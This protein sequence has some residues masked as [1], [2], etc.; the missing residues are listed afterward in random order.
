MTSPSAPSAPGVRRAARRFL[1]GTRAGATL[2]VTAAVAVMSVAAFAFVV[3]HIWLVDQRDVLKSAASAAAV[4][5]TNEM[6][7]RLVPSPDMS[8]ADLTAALTP[9]ARNYLELNLAYL[10]TDRLTRAKE[11][12]ALTVTPN[13]DWARW[14]WRRQRTSAASCSPGTCRC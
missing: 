10:S 13:R 7:R 12:L 1:A 6:D 8:Q 5:A 3:D 9:V 11:T 4:A 14:T 2:I